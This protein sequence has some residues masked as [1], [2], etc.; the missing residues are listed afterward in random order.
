MCCCYCCCCRCCHCSC[1]SF[2]TVAVV[3]T[4]VVACGISVESGRLDTVL[5]LVSLGLTCFTDRTGKTNLMQSARAGNDVI[6][7]YLLAHA[8][9]LGLDL[10]AV[11]TKGENALFYAVRSRRASVVSALLGQVIGHALLGHALL[12]QVKFHALLDHVYSIRPEVKFHSVVLKSCRLLCAIMMLADE[13]N[14]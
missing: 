1:Y 12:G 4:I 10:A 3:V 11:D 7:A 13:C 8:Q 5:Y 14:E 6:T 2:F 9:T